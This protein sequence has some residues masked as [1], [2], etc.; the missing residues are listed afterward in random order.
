MFHRITVLDVVL[1]RILTGEKI[2][3]R[4]LA[5]LGHGGLCRNCPTCRYP[6]CSFCR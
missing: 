1:P 4:E 3:R 6:A 5:A 2:G